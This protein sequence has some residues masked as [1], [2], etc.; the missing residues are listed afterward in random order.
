MPTRKDKWIVRYIENRL[1]S[2][3]GDILKGRSIK[4]EFLLVIKIKDKK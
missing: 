1:K 3:H 2:E 4:I